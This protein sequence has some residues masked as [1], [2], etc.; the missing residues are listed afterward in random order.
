[1]A[2]PNF[3]PI[4]VNFY[5]RSV[6]ETTVPQLNQY[7]GVS[8][9][10]GTQRN[11]T[12]TSP[13]IDLRGIATGFND[14][15]NNYGQSTTLTNDT[16]SAT[17]YS[18]IV[19]PSAN[20]LNNNGLPF[21]GSYSSGQVPPSSNGGITGGSN[22]GSSNN[23]TSDSNS[24]DRRVKIRDNTN[25]MTPSLVVFPYT[26]TITVSH[27]AN[28]EV[29]NLIHSAYSTPYFTHSSVDT[30]NVQGRFTA[31]NEKEAQHIRDM[32]QFF[33]TATKMFYGASTPK[34][35][36]PPVVQFSGYGNLF[37]DDGGETGIP[38]VVRDFSYTLPNDVNYISA[39]SSQ[40]P[41]DL[42]ITVD[43]L[44]VYSRN[45]IESF[46]IKSYAK[47]GGMWI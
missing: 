24:K 26:P 18:P 27:K 15:T 33:R 45:F 40:I 32:I 34:G 9:T 6:T 17:N 31:Q 35:A 1:M 13:N 10:P 7:T 20:R 42:S 41:T 16:S 4:P 21:G 28:Y 25:T 36:P 23:L 30:I 12:N 46:D 37:G 38:V 5:N 11:Q 2:E 3:T 14:Q 19:D 47:G 44:P 39:G 22:S 43:L 8:I 29:E